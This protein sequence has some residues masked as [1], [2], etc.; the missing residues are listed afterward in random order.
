M[1]CVSSVTYSVLINGTPYG[2]IKPERGIRQGDPLSPFLFVLCTEALIHLL[3]QAKRENKVEGIQFNNAGPSINH[4]LFADDTLLMCK[5]NKEEC[6]A[7]LL[8]LSKYERLSGQMI[9][10]DKLAIT[11]GI[12]VNPEIKNWVKMRSGIKTEGGTWKYLGLPECLSG[13]KQQLLGFIKDRLQTRMSS[14][15]AKTLSQGRK[16]ILLKSIAMALPV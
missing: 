13:S 16:E 1:G 4:I 12:N 3:E 11:F 9:N 8:C 14:W 2:F 15:F 5:A 6:E 7:I 10:L